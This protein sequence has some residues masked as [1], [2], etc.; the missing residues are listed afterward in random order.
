MKILIP[1]K[2]NPDRYKKV[3]QEMLKLGPPII[4]CIEISNDY[5]YALE[6]SHRLNAA[7][8][9][10]LIPIINIITELTDLDDTLYSIKLNIQTRIKKNLLINF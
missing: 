3:F 8:E 7:K 1:N 4:D 5:Y 10:N 2:I 6:G 9:L